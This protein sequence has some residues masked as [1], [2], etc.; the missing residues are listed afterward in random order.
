MHSEVDK[1]HWHDM[2]LLSPGQWAI[3][4]VGPCIII[5]VTTL[6]FM[7][8]STTGE[9]N[10]CPGKL[11]AWPLIHPNPVM[12]SPPLP[13]HPFQDTDPL[14][15]LLLFLLLGQEGLQLLLHARQLLWVHPGNK[16]ILCES[17]N[18]ICKIYSK[19][20]QKV[21]DAW[22]IMEK[23]FL[24]PPPHRF[25][26]WSETNLPFISKV[27]YMHT[28][29]AWKQLIYHHHHNWTRDHFSQKKSQN[30]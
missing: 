7:G 6:D 25:L 22:T 21:T 2:F 28:W 29:W 8:V 19:K 14:C 16:K 12:V 10:S 3:V 30:I 20:G 23:S 13:L 1:I 17:T 18:H 27:I 11:M 26:E 5:P 9:N 24:T 4:N 15:S